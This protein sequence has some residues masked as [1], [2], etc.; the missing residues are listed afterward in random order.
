MESKDTNSNQMNNL[1]ELL[2]AEMLQNKNEAWNKL[3]SASKIQK[4]YEYAENNY[5]I[6]DEINL[7]KVFFAE[8]I[9]KGKLKKVKDVE[10]DKETGIISGVPGLFYNGNNKRFTIKNMEK[11][12]S[13]M[14]S[15][16][17]KRML[18]KNKS[19]SN[20]Q[21]SVENVNDEKEI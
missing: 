18:L 6:E 8:C 9:E 16:T 17:P 11:R 3:D 21:R 5:S 20:K 19:V 14:K 2:E 4:L 10:Y 12:V 15:L 1:N 7:L 13:T